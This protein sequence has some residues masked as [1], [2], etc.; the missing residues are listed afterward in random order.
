MTGALR[1]GAPSSR[2]PTWITIRPLSPTDGDFRADHSNDAK[3]ISEK[4]PLKRKGA[5]RL[6]DGRLDRTRP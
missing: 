5:D 1:R 2:S 6:V 3:W 4:R